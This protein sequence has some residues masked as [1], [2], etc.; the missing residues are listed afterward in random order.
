MKKSCLKG[1]AE[2]FR[3]KKYLATRAKALLEEEAQSTPKKQKRVKNLE[4]DNPELFKTLQNWRTTQAE[5][6]DVP[7]SRVATLASLVAISN[8]LPPT[9]TRLK[10]IHGMGPARLKKYGEALLDMVESFKKEP[11]PDA[12][13]KMRTTRSIQQE[14][15]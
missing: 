10:A 6:E 13:K 15:L 1:C 12:A 2:G 7:P 8:E 11:K 5:K 3:V 9:R 14:L 4:S